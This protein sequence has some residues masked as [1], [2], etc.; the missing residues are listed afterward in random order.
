ME[1]QQVCWG[2]AD[3]FSHGLVPH[4]TAGADDNDCSSDG[5]DFVEWLVE[6]RPT[7]GGNWTRP[8]GR[9]ASGRVD[10]GRRNAE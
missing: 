3:P 6:F 8:G 7:A 10:I 2:E 5:S 9:E 4:R 1:H